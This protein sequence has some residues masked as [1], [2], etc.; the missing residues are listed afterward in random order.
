MSCFLTGEHPEHGKLW[1]AVDPDAHH[2][3]GR[4]CQRRFAAY[5]APFR[6]EE[7]ALQVLLAAGAVLEDPTAPRSNQRQSSRKEQR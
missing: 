1:A 5:L 4:V 7:E 2:L 6:S 3:S